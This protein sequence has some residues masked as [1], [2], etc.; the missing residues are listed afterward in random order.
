MAEQ[1][2]DVIVIGGGIAGCATAYY[3]A[4]RNTK[5]VLM[6]KGE[7]AD[8]QSSRAWGF[9]RQ[10]GRSPAEI[11]LM[12]A[13][14]RM[15]QALSQELNADVEWVQ[16]GLLALAPDDNMMESFRRWL[17]VGRDYGVDTRLVTGGEV[18]ELVP[19][20][21]GQWAGGMYTPSDGHAE[22]RKATTAFA[23]AAQEHGADLLT[24]SPVQ[25]LEVTEGR[26]SG[27]VTDRGTIWAPVV[28][29]AA[30]AWS[31]RLAK[32]VGLSMPQQVVR[33][34]V[35]ETLPAPPITSMGLWVPDLGLRQRPGGSC[36]IAAGPVADY[37]VTLDSFR[38]LRMFLPNY[39][40]NR[41]FFQVNLGRDLVKDAARSLRGPLGR[42]RSFP[43][44]VGVEPTPNPKAVDR[45]LR[46][47]RELFPSQSSLGLQRVWAGRIDVTPDLLPILGEV[48]KPK[49]LIFATGFSGHGFAMGPIIGRLV[50]ELILD[51]KTSLDISPF[52]LSRFA[53][54][55][56]ERDRGL[57]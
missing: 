45:A 5:V 1:Q 29:C 42:Q 57:V 49:G 24:S 30:G 16:E 6:E 32:G 13:S 10:Q 17:Q 11:P 56:W 14:N 43:V 54:G 12:V 9:V 4:K 53:E 33:A 52:R 44:G 7:I 38:H 41:G 18:K 27:V 20:L 15:W 25:E 23:R 46:R 35:A 34:T 40:R 22:P 19:A 28:V 21:A 39:L 26:V 47:F 48:E 2:A 3:L 8:E 50:S 51:G 31:F 36:Y 55:A 37:D